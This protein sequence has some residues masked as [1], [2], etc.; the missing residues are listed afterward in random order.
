MLYLQIFCILLTRF[1]S[2][3]TVYRRKPI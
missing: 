3:G 2:G 1:I